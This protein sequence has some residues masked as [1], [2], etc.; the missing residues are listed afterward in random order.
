MTVLQGNARAKKD[1]TIN[2]HYHIQ[3]VVALFYGDSPVFLPEIR[4]AYCHAHDKKWL[5]SFAPT[6]LRRSEY[7][8]ISY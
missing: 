4:S 1:A 6:A 2:C 7:L 5:V 3:V 8:A